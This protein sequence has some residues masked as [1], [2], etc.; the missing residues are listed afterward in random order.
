VPGV[1]LPSWMP[2]DY[3]ICYNPADDICTQT[4]AKG[5]N[6]LYPADPSKSYNGVGTNKGDP[7][8]GTCVNY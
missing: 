3:D 4:T 7:G 5:V 6:G 2:K 8:Q 1:S